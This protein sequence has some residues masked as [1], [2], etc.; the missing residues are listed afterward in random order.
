MDRLHPALLACLLTTVVPGMLL[1]NGPDPRLEAGAPVSLLAV[2]RDPHQLSDSAAPSAP[3]FPSLKPRSSESATD[4]Q[5]TEPRT[6]KIAAPTITVVSSLA[7]VL[8]LF[9]AL[10]WGSR[11]FGNGSSHSRF[12]PKEVMQPLGST[13]LDPR[14]R[15]TMLRC[16]SR[17]LVIAQGASNTQ[18]LCE[19]NDPE[20]VRRITAACQGD[21]QHDF[22]S[23]LRSLEQEPVSR[24]Y[25]GTEQDHTP[26]PPRR[27]L[28]ASA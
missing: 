21:A 9:A 23:A 6:S 27:R 11:K 2:N 15:I 1:G 4:R 8:G 5:A 16:G 22:A 18:T 24:D 26:T 7:V 10:V 14:T 20:E 3:T 28:F 13:P 17:I 25:A 19:I 12:L